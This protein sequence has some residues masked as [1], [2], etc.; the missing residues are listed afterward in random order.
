MQD[1]TSSSSANQTFLAEDLIEKEQIGSLQFPQTD[2][3]TND[4]E[5]RRRSHD[6]ERACTLGNVHHGK[7]H[8]HFQTADGHHY[9]ADT[10]IWACDSDYVTLKAG[11]SLPVR[12]ISQIEFI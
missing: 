5:R 4:Q 10:T 12:A 7:V 9:R 2:V 1:A 11:A 3:L 8:I 6:I